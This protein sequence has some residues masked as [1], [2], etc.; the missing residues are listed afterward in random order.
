[1]ILN[2]R[3]QR[4]AEDDIPKVP[5][6]LSHTTGDVSRSLQHI[7]GPVVLPNLTQAMGCCDVTREAEC[8]FAALRALRTQG[9]LLPVDPDW[10]AD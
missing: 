10:T 6:L 8:S 3:D 5:T 2:K 9:E 1:M 4:K 7:K